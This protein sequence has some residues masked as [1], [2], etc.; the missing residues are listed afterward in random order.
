MTVKVDLCRTCQSLR[1]GEV[2]FVPVVLLLKL[3]N[4]NPNM[5]N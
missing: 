1:Y 2:L 4:F 5:D 3:I